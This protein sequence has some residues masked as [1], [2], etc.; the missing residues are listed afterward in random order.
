MLLIN[1][2]LNEEVK[3]LGHP[4][5][6]HK[7]RVHEEDPLGPVSVKYDSEKPDWSLLP[8]SIISGVVRVLTFGKK[9]YSVN[10]WKAV[11]PIR[12]YSAMMRHLEYIANGELYDKESGEH[13]MFHFL[14]N[15]LFLTWYSVVK[16]DTTWIKTIFGKEE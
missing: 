5:N 13:H 15:A 14:C 2:Q 10:G 16:L 11:E 6:K 12:V 3:G 1:I 4:G 7:S 8:L 9:K